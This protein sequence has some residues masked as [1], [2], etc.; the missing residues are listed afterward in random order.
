[1]GSTHAEAG[2]MTDLEGRALDEALARAMAR[3]GV[4]RG[5]DKGGEMRRPASVKKSG[6]YVVKSAADGSLLVTPAWPQFRPYDDED[7][8]GPGLGSRLQLAADLQAWLNEER[9]R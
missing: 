3:Q 7:G 5:A 8:G 2:I 6:P 1:M 4:P 9:D